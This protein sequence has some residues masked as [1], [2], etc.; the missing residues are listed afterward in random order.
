MKSMAAMLDGLVT[1]ERLAAFGQ[2]VI[3]GVGACTAFAGL[4]LRAGSRD[5]DVA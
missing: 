1:M 3:L 5:C 2:Y 4:I